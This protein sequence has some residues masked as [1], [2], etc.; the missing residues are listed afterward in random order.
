[1]RSSLRV[2]TT[3][4]RCYSAS[5]TICSGVFRQYT[6]KRYMVLD[7]VT[8]ITPVLRHFI[9]C[10]CDSALNSSWQLLCLQGAKW[11][12]FAMSGWWP[13]AYHYYRLLTTTTLIID[14]PTSLR[15]RSQEL[16]Q[17]C[18]IAH[19]CWTTWFWAYSVGVPAATEHAPV[20]LRPRRRV[21]VAFT[22]SN[23]F[24]FTL[25]Y[26]TRRWSHRTMWIVTSGYDLWLQ[27]SL[28]HDNTQA[29][30]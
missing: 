24:A 4:T 12:V 14:H 5:L 15:V 11:L 30:I 17:V 23:K 26:V 6:T 3:V 28:L 13:S 2:L 19:C 10:Q 27:V 18:V 21:T 1:M 20:S 9:G 25:H 29:Y 22:A 8:R 7:V 16:T